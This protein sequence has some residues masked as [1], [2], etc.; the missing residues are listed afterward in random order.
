MKTKKSSKVDITNL[1]DVEIYLLVREGII[2]RFPQSFLNEFS[3]KRI[4]R[5]LCL[6]N[7]HMT[8][9]EICNIR[10]DFLF[11]N[12][13]GG[14]RKIFDYNMFSLIQY[15]FPELNIKHW[16]T[17]KVSDHFWEDKENQREFV[18]WMAEK[19]KIDLNNL[20][21][22]SK[23]TANMLTKYGGSK[24]RRIAG[25]TFELISSA[26]GNKFQEW[27]IFKM[28]VWTEEKAIKAV[29]WLIEQKLKWSNEQIQEY[30]TASVFQKNHLG[31]LLK[32]YCNNSPLKAIN[33][34]YPGRFKSLKYS[35]P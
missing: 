25:G 14:F 10:Q 27:E 2:S 28:D 29:K 8:R 1:S 4:L 31:G 13:L 3:C 30:L 23:I 22:V 35:R 24:A 17:A 11:L 20:K 18:E 12:S 7:Y 6:E 21:D 33:I 19:E 34:A 16:E 9:D 32:N 26:T 5:W 15:C